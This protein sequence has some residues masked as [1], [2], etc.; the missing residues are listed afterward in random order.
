M[1]FDNLQVSHERGPI[2]EETHYYPFGLTQLG[3]SSKAL[4]FGSPN[5]KLKYNGKEEQRQEFSDGSGLEWTDYGARMYDQQIGRWHVVDPITEYSRRWSPYNY[6]Y[7][8][9]LRFIDPDGMLA[10]DW[11]TG[12]YLDEN[13]GEV[14][15]SD[16]MDQ[17]K[18]SGTTIYEAD[19]E[20]EDPEKMRNNKGYSHHKPKGIFSPVN[21]AE[22][23]KKY[24]LIKRIYSNRK[25]NRSEFKRDEFM[26]KMIQFSTGFAAGNFLQQLLGSKGLGNLYQVIMAGLTGV[27]LENIE[28]QNG[29][30]YETA[31]V[32][33][34]YG[35]LRWNG[36]SGKVI[37]QDYYG[38]EK[39]Y[40]TVLQIY[41]THRLIDK[42][43]GRVIV[44]FPMTVGSHPN[45]A[46]NPS[47]TL[48][49]RD[50][51]TFD[52]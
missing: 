30:L 52:D 11:N 46:T 18:G 6:A 21:E 51:G 35:K 39:E 27:A 1:F 32:G 23:T 5:N 17:M 2:L 48:E 13:G 16:A 22:F 43:T 20:G 45:Y 38:F 7:D 31:E 10:Y 37:A 49:L 8:N 33:N 40:L 41:Q 44:N 24:P 50:F 3:I 12:K 15:N 9:P 36:R 14:S 34:W 28:Y 4:A 19:D 25:W 26:T 42:S 29:T 47:E